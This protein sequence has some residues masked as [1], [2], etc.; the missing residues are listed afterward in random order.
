MHWVTE[1]IPDESYLYRRVHGSDFKPT[2]ELN[3]NAFRDYDMS[4]D[5]DRYCSASDSQKGGRHE[6]KRYAVVRFKVR[7][8]RG[9]PDQTVKHTPDVENK[10][11]AHTSVIGPKKSPETRLKFFLIHE[12]VIPLAPDWRT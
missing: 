11:L 2:G 12:P 4:C 3:P 1:E 5:W 8:I 9:I 6:P 7:A 10:N